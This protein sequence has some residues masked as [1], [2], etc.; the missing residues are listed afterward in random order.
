VKVT[1]TK[2]VLLTEKGTFKNVPRP[3]STSEIPLIGQMY[4]YTEKKKG[5]YSFFKYGSAAAALFLVILT[6]FIF[7]FGGSAEEALIV[8][9]DVNPSIE[10][11]ADEN[12]Q[13][14]HAEGLNEDGRKLL[15]S[16]QLEDELYSVIDQ[17][18]DETINQGF[19]AIEGALIATSVVSI[20]EDLEEVT[21]RV[22]KVIE[23][24]LEE[25]DATAEIDLGNDNHEL[26]EE[27][28][29]SNLSINYY[30]KYKRLKDSG[31]VN[32]QKEIKGKS[33]A[34][35]KKLENKKRKKE[36]EVD[37]KPQQEN[38]GTPGNNNESGRTKPENNGNSS[39]ENGPQKPKDDS[40]NKSEKARD[41]GNKSQ[42]EKEQKGNQG[43]IRGNQESPSKTSK[44]N[45]GNK[46]QQSNG[47]GLKTRNSSNE[48]EKK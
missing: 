27:A 17:I 5:N 3:T 18:V 44:E 28:K 30:K 46:P 25:H 38:N 37:K 47:N 6:S 8:T 34:E 14:I 15:S 32:D 45:K 19:V 11:M 24:S 23:A 48:R 1:E 10:L 35:L 16:L 29:Q 12:L 42:S 7:P 22:K 2:I 21:P 36:K 41:N 31:V 9:I 43:K 20:Q 4:T 26:Y 39:K 33:L 13:V 40:G